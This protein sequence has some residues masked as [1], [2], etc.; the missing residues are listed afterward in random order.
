MS[1]ERLFKLMPTQPTLPASP[2]KILAVGLLVCVFLTSLAIVGGVFWLRSAFQRPADP[3]IQLAQNR[4]RSQPT[5]P[6]GRSTPVFAAVTTTKNAILADKIKTSL[7]GDDIFKD[8]HIPR[9]K[10]TVPPEG[11]S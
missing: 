11:M 8:L 5:L 1:G 7:P 9:L 3:Q 6:P 2:L 10:I 4:S